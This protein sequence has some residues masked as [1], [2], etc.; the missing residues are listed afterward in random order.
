MS[1]EKYY[2]DEVRKRV[3]GCKQ[4]LCVSSFP[5][6]GINTILVDQPKHVF[7]PILNH[8]WKSEFVHEISPQ[9]IVLSAKIGA[10]VHISPGC[11][12]GEE[13]EIGDNTVLHPNVTIEGPC[14]IGHDCEVGNY[15]RID[16]QCT[17]VGGTKMLNG[18]TVHTGSVINH[19]VVVG[20]NAVV[21][22]CS[23]VIRKVNPN[24]TVQ[25]NPARKVEY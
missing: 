18:S 12:V 16:N 9:A 23:F 19:G 21:G 17:C 14:V 22:A 5:L 13:V 15:V 4:I 10:N 3:A 24:T 20:E 7:F 6:E 1:D 11:Y 2:T 8:F 25:G